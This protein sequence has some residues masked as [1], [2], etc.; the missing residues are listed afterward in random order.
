MLQGAL[1]IEDV[2]LRLRAAIRRL[3]EE[4][5]VLV[6]P[7]G[8]VRLAAVQLFFSR[9]G[10]RSYLIVHRPGLKTR[11]IQRPASWDVRSFASDV[12]PGALDL[13]QSDHVKRLE[14][15]LARLDLDGK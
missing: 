2:R 7:R 14:G 10:S 11:A 15:W 4:A 3:V 9:G 13:R 1:D 12:A 5:W 6:V 8:R